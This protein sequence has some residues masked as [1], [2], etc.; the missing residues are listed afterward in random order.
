M[1]T[2]YAALDDRLLV[3][4]G[5]A[6]DL[7]AHQRL[8]ATALECVAAHP[9]RPDRVFVGTVDAGLHLSRDGGRSWSVV[10][11]FAERDERVT[12]LHVRPDDPATVFAGT[13][14]SRVYRS[15]DGGD[16]WQER[17]GLVDLPT[18]DRWSFPPRPHT[19]HVRW[20]DAA[21]DDPE[22]LY[23]AIE[24]GAFV[25]SPDAGETWLPHPDGARRDNHTIATHPEAPGRV[26]VAAGDGYAV[27]DDRG[28]SWRYP[29]AGLE[30]RYVW[31]VAID[32]GDPDRVLVS[33]ATGAASA[34]RPEGAESYVYRRQDPPDE[35]TGQ[36]D[37][38]MDG[39]D[40]AAGLVRPVLATDGTPGR[41][42]AL[43]N[44]G[45]FRS[46]DA[47]GSWDQLTG[48]H[49]GVYAGKVPR[50]LAVVADGSDPRR[51]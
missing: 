24:A 46:D 19:H 23:V 15:T 4:R 41:F 9:G 25:R 31:S 2:V 16:T 35:T 7:T 43:T 45:L 6:G 26:Y 48:G 27:S 49:A 13:E 36:W 1:P 47:G 21:P 44:R 39:L 12:S 11:S 51:T 38:A 10:G 18:S 22:R 28:E 40:P 29:Q 37:L 33:A 42:Y 14:P 3:F 5:G 30:H 20:I 8:P 32:P 34:H 17:G 50:G